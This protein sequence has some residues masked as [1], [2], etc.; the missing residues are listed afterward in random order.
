MT[1]KLLIEALDARYQP[2]GAIQMALSWLESALNCKQFEWD[3]DQREWAAESL[4]DAKAE[5]SALKEAAHRSQQEAVQEPVEGL[6]E[7]QALRLGAMQHLDGTIAVSLPRDLALRL[8]SSEV[9]ELARL[10]EVA[11]SPAPS[12]SEALRPL[13]YG[14]NDIQWLKA[15]HGALPKLLKVAEVEQQ[16][17][18]FVTV[19]GDLIARLETERAE[20]AALS[21]SGQKGAPT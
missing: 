8:L 12:G 9:R 16:G 11:F 4:K 10:F 3:A 13:P 7:Q 15:I 19:L 6:T 5:W 18:D 1:D 17:A 14:P 2:D 21:A 20:R